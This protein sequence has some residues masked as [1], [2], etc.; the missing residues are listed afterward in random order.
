M[1]KSEDLGQAP[2]NWM[3]TLSGKK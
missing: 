2:C 1:C 3:E